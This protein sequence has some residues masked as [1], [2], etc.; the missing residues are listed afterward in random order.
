M[1]RRLILLLSLG[2]CL[3]GLAL[4]YYALVPMQ[5]PATL[6]AEFSIHSGSTLRS[7][8]NQLHRQGLL[9]HPYAFIVLG[10][11]MGKAGEV[12]AGSYS[13]DQATTPYA[14]LQKITRGETL[15][16]KVTVIEGW[17]FRQMRAALDANPRLKHD[18]Q[19]MSDR[20]LL[21]AIGA[22]EMQPEGIFF[23]DTYY[24]DVGGSDIEVYRR[25]YH[26]M[27]EVLAQA[28]AERSEPL[29]Y[30]NPYQV[31]IMASII[32]KETGAPEERPL[33]AAVFVNRLRIGM[34][35]Q[36]DPTVIYGLGSRFDGNLR[37][38]DLLTDTPYN[39]YTRA[40]LPPTPIA[41]P[42]EAAILAA[43]APADTKALYFVATGGGRHK[44]SNTLE[45]HNRAVNRYQRGGG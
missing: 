11:L 43:L 20:E 38:T 13:L 22:P 32:E 24:F 9:E 26:A 37:K 12:K 3:M 17:T 7:V 4:G 8:S 28:W 10:R 45:E 18:T 41:L 31:L 36:T 2:V 23:P 29:P 16:G 25:A 44:F 40:G 33:I 1:I 14:L 5:Q 15:L 39:T 34:R 6:P 27:Q 21:A 35:L 19:G 42:G 30:A